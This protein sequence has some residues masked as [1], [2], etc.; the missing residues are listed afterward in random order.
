MKPSIEPHALAGEPPTELPWQ[1]PAYAE[2]VAATREAGA[3]VYDPAGLLLE[4]T[5]RGPAY[6]R[7]DTH[8]RPEV[9]EAV[10]E[11]LASEIERLVDLTP[12]SESYRRQVVKVSN[13]GDLFDLLGLPD[14]QTLVAL[15]EVELRRVTDGRRR[16]WQPDE[17]AEVLLLGDSFTNVFSMP[18]LGWGEGLEGFLHGRDATGR[19]ARACRASPAWVTRSRGGSGWRPRKPIRC[20]WRSSWP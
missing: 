7:A 14:G 8:W 3:E 6:L 4:T 9:V 16:L 15:E 20:A 11:E 17:G 5:S 10:A 19:S 18:E 12:P 13:R 1:N 2:W